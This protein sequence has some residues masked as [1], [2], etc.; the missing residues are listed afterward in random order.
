[1]IALDRW[2]DIS[3]FAPSVIL[4]PILYQ[5]Y[6]S[7]PLKDYLLEIRPEDISSVIPNERIIKS[8]FRQDQ[9]YRIKPKLDIVLGSYYDLIIKSYSYTYSTINYSDGSRDYDDYNIQS[10]IDAVTQITKI[11]TPISNNLLHLVIKIQNIYVKKSYTRN[12]SGQDPKIMLDFSP[13]R[14]LAMEELEIRGNPEYDPE[15]FSNRD[16]WV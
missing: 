10:A 6:Y 7:A 3:S 9:I 8:L 12:Y 15:I 16:G 11:N 1:L 13:V 2:K 14:K 5:K 4:E